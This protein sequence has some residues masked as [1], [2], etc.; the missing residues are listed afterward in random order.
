MEASVE[1]KNARFL[2]QKAIVKHLL[3]SY[4]TSAGRT[5]VGIISNSNPPKA[6]VT[7]GQ[8]HGDRLKEEIDKLLQGQAGLLLDSLNFAT[9]RMFTPMNGARSG[10]KKILIVFVNEKVKSD[11]PAMDSV[12]KKLKNSG[13]NVIVIGLDPTLD[14]ENILAA[15]PSNE[16]FLFPPSL[17]ELDLSL[18]PIVLATYPGLFLFHICWPN[19]IISLITVSCKMCWSTIFG[20]LSFILI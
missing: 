19:C 1:D 13:I 6:V 17:E 20:F 2:K 10:A 3:T 7:I 18:Y 8:Y 4:D 9:D 5:H 16:V 12:G 11:K 15:S 14:A